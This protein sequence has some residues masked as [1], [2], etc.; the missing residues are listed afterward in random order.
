MAASLGYERASVLELGV[1]GG[2]GLVYL[3]SIKSEVER[4]S[5]VT[6]EIYGFDTTEG[7]PEPRSYKDLPYKWKQGFYNMDVD[8]LL[9]KLECS[10]LVIG[11]VAE[12]SKTFFDEY[13]P[14]PIC[15]VM[16]DMDFYSS[17]KDA[18]RLF[19]CDDSRILPRFYCYFDDTVGG[20]DEMYTEFVGQRLAISEFNAEH[21]DAKIGIPFHL[22]A[23]NT[24][25]NWPQKIWIYSRFS[26]KDF[27]TFIAE[28]NQ[29]LELT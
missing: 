20:V 8:A 24:S 13:D 16:H 28:E 29:Q 22:R 6:I 21:E 10:K 11:D 9:T 12:T 27:S 7:L 4:L 19:D 5:G 23:I 25:R 18:L 3:E 15:A 2:N 26:H 14:A 1:A 17:T